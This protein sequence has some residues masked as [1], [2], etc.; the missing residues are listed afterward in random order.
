MQM[1]QEYF[2]AVAEFRQELL[3]RG[4]A[5]EAMAEDRSVAWPAGGSRNLILGQDT[6]VELGNPREGSC[7]F[8]L[9][10]RDEGWV[11]DGRMTIAGPD[12]PDCEGKSLPFGLVILI[13]GNDFTSENAWERYRQ[14]E[15]KRYEVD[16]KGYMMR[17][18]SQNQ[19]EWSRVSREARQNGFSFPVLGQAM[20]STFKSLPWITAFEVLFVTSSRKDVAALQ[21]IGEKAGR[22]VAAMNK[23]LEELSFDCGVCEYR[24]VCSDVAALR[25]MRKTLLKEK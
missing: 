19:R 1:F 5:R 22:I 15:G 14:M 18:V 17:A 25:S 2:Q 12:I 13:A 24:D 7:S 3:A 20:R 9:W 10:G 8:M 6:A 21:R 23:M 16:L 11:K 4:D